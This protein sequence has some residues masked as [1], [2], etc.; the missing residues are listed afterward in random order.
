MW[1]LFHLMLIQRFLKLSSLFFFHFFLFCCSEWLLLFFLPACWSDLRLHPVCWIAL[2]YFSVQ[3]LY[4]SALYLLLGILLYF[5]CWGSVFIQFS[6]DF[7][8][9]LYD[10]STLN[11]QICCFFPFHQCHFLMFC[12]VLFGTF[13]VSFLPDSPCLFLCTR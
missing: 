11:Y 12:H 2:V 10:H 13:Y 3:L 7:S 6:S 8:E 9:H 5:L 4:C 1:M